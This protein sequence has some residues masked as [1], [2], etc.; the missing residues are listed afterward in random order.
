MKKITA[1]LTIIIVFL[2][3]LVTFAQAAD[4]TMSFTP[5]TGNFQV[6]EEFD[7]A[8]NLDTAGQKIVAADARLEFSADKL[9]VKVI[10]EGGISGTY[11]TNF[12]NQTGL[13]TINVFAFD[14]FSWSGSLAT[15]TFS[16]KSAGTAEVELVFDPTDASDDSSVAV[17]GE[18]TDQLSSV[19]SASYTLAG[20]EEPTVTPVPTSTPAPTATATP[21]L[22]LTS[23]PT[24]TS[25]LGEVGE[26]PGTGLVE[27]TYSLFFIGVGILLIGGSLLF[28]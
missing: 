18:V 12:D 10:S 13:V 8:I 15:L 1:L 17:L 6:G 7:V 24:P 20:G 9:E 26:L 16:A 27:W 11:V 21:I 23:T 14:G 19:T 22:S 5:S 4:V 3:G 2:F 25:A 28:R